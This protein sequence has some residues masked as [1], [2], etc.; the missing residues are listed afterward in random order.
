V[1]FLPTWDA[2]LLAHARRTEILPQRYRS[3]V[4]GTKTPHSVSTFL[5][6]GSVAGSWRYENG[7]IRLDPFEPLSRTVR[8]EL[9]DEVA[10]LAAFHEDKG[11][12]DNSGR[13]YDPVYR[14][15]ER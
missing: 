15:A 2:T 11:V 5:V 14:S 12:G 6:D 3:R 7:H 4:F 9:E 1:R 8:R 13:R 10:R